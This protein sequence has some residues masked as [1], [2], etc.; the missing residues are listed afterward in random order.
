MIAING[1]SADE[2][3]FEAAHKLILDETPI[4]DSRSGFTKE[5]LHVGFSIKNPRNRWVTSRLPPINPA[6]A[7][8]EVVWIMNGSNDAN[9]IN[10][11]NPALPRYAGQTDY[12]HGA[13]G[14]RLRKHFKS[15]QLVR[16]Y[17]VLLNN[18]K[19]RQVV[20]QIWDSNIDLPNKKGIP[21]AADIPCNICALLKIRDNKLEWCQII[22]SNDLFRGLPYNFVQFT[23]I[24]EI[25]SGWLGVELGTY[26]QLSD[27]LH[28][29]TSDIES[30]KI[31]KNPNENEKSFDNL[32][33]PYQDSVNCF[34]SLFNAMQQMVAIDIT[35]QDF[36][37][38]FTN[39]INPQA[40]Q[41]I[42]LVIGADIARRKGW[43]SLSDRL[44]D[45]CTNLLYKRL[46]KK[47]SRHIKK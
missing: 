8:A 27:S 46:W 47:W 19:S 33:L 28:L 16:A 45:D 17:R 15:D 29:Y 20:L 14:F 1:N 2:V 12:Y 35:H 13:Y 25:L 18:Q 32:A 38:L 10:Q 3:W 31:L 6:F 4:T 41:N 37:N 43:S 44:I 36:I 30:L 34:H 21:T 24:Q 23:T 26:N 5:L 22:R 39:G 40:F 42:L 9:I 7:L 11:W